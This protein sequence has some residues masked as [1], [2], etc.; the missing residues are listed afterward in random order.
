L[1]HEKRNILL[2]LNAQFFRCQLFVDDLLEI[3]FAYGLWAVARL[4]RNRAY[5]ANNQ[6]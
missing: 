6:E 5:G 1:G 4:K 2:G 3:G